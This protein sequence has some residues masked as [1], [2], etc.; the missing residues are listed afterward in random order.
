MDSHLQLLLEKSLSENEINNFNIKRLSKTATTEYLQISFNLEYL[1]N[2][3][4]LMDLFIVD[5]TVA[6]S[7]ISAFVS[8]EKHNKY[9][10]LE[11]INNLSTAFKGTLCFVLDKDGKIDILNECFSDNG[12]PLELCKQITNYILFLTSDCK[13]VLYDIY[14]NY[15]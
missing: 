6:H 15:S 11:L 3:E 2:K 8:T 7:V 5:N 1:N 10:T 13:N 4:I 14:K 9:Y 12:S